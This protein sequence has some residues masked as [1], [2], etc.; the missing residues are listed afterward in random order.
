MSR[1]LLSLLVLAAILLPGVFYLLLRVAQLY[2]PGPFENAAFWAFAISYPF[3]LLL[4][5]VMAAP[6]SA[7]LFTMLLSA[8]LLCNAALYVFVG[9]AFVRTH[10]WLMRRSVRST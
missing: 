5:A 4:W 6:N 9:F 8:S 2:L 3:W 1:R 7:L 10:A